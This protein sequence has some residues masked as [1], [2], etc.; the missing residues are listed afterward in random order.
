VAQVFEP[1]RLLLAA[2]EAFF[3]SACLMWMLCKKGP[4]CSF[5]LGRFF[6]AFYSNASGPFSS[7]LRPNVSGVLFMHGSHLSIVAIYPCK[8]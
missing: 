1:A 3:C 4:A 8:Q 7:G 2:P 6:S 5:G